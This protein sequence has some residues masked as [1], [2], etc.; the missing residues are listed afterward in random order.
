MYVLLYQKFDDD[1]SKWWQDYVD[2]QF[3]VNWIKCCSRKYVFKYK[4]IIPGVSFT[5]VMKHLGCYNNQCHDG[6]KVKLDIDKDEKYIKSIPHDNETAD[7]LIDFAFNGG[8]EYIYTKTK[9]NI[10]FTHYNDSWQWIA[11]QKLSLIFEGRI[12]YRSLNKN[13][14]NPWQVLH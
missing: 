13:G 14:T 6:I 2:T 7:W 11:N 9:D 8:Q 5:S 12:K 3:G 10:Q 1:E 4:I